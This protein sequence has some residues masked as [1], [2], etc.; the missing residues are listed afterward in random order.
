[1]TAKWITVRWFAP[2]PRCGAGVKSDGKC[3]SC[4]LQMPRFSLN[5]GGRRYEDREELI[6]E[7]FDAAAGDLG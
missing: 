3:L 4:G 6:H 5:K 1:M 7:Y 2:C